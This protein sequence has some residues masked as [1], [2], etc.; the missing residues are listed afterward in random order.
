MVSIVFVVPAKVIVADSQP[1]FAEALAAGLGADARWTVSSMFPSSG[2]ETMSAVLSEKPDLA[3]VDLWL[4]GMNGPPIAHRLQRQ[5]PGCKVIL[6]SS[7]YGADD[8]RYAFEAGAVGFLSKQISLR[9]LGDAL[10]RAHE[11]A[12]PVFSSDLEAI[13][14][15]LDRRNPT[16]AR[17]LDKFAS[18]TSRELDVLSHLGSGAPLGEVAA[19]LGISPKTLKN[20]ISKI[21]HKTGA[22]SPAQAFTMARSCGLID[23]GTEVRGSR[24]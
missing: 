14:V 4:R 15:R 11:G 16:M 20:H 5:S 13:M 7:F 6:L 2:P 1:L 8:V 17:T 10:S 23:T 21:L 24:S 3:L 22:A 19:A 12:L 18:V 9:E